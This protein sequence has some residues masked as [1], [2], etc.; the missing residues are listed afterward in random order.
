MEKMFSYAAQA[1][2]GTASTTLRPTK[3]AC[4]TVFHFDKDSNVFKLVQNAQVNLQHCI[5]GYDKSVMLK[6]DFNSAGQT[7]PTVVKKPNKVIFLNQLVELADDG[8]WID[9]RIFTHGVQGGIIMNNGMGNADLHITREDLL[10][11]A[12][13]TK[14]GI[15]PIRSVYGCN[16]NGASLTQTWIDIGAIVAGGSYDTYFY[17]NTM[18]DFHREWNKGNVTFEE[19]IERSHTDTA[20]TVMQTLIAADAASQLFPKEW[21]KCMPGSTVLGDKPCAKSYFSAEWGLG[22]CW[23]EGQSGKENMNY[24]SRMIVAGQNITRNNKDVLVWKA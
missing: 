3:S 8:Y 2:A 9:V 19:A 24:A 23:Q 13:E 15:I 22:N 16:C 5:D 11:A 1:S 17:A 7:K 18:N 12:K 20:R 10:A 21:N 4:L 14:H 6:E